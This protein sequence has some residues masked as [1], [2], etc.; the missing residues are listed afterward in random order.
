MF[1]FYLNPGKSYPLPVLSHPLS[2]RKT[3]CVA[4]FWYFFLS[5]SLSIS[6]ARTWKQPANYGSHWYECLLDAHLVFEFLSNLYAE[7]FGYD[8]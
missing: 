2:L 1:P 6:L 3:C 7:C 4:Q 8:K 5:L